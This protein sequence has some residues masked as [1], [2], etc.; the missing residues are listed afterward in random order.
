MVSLQHHDRAARINE[1]PGG[2]GAAWPAPEERLLYGAVVSGDGPIDAHPTAM[3]AIGRRR[4]KPRDLPHGGRSVEGSGPMGPIVRRPIEK[5]ERMA[6]RKPTSA[7][8]IPGLGRFISTNGFET[9]KQE[10][11]AD[12][13]PAGRAREISG[14]LS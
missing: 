14:A 9:F 4:L 8:A 12:P 13:S 2:D 3:E 1:R 11:G 10:S 5:A 7:T 6:A